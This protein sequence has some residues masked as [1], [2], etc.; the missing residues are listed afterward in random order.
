MSSMQTD[1]AFQPFSAMTD[2]R[3]YSYFAGM[4]PTRVALS[5]GV[6]HFCFCS[7]SHAS[8]RHMKYVLPGGNCWRWRLRTTHLNF[9]LRF[10]HFLN[11]E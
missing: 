1:V 11:H 3:S 9:K 8:Y 10:T 5:C 2:S 4:M 7:L 6:L